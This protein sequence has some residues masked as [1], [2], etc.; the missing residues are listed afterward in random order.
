MERP[1]QGFT[2]RQL[3]WMRRWHSQAHL[4]THLGTRPSTP[5]EW[6]TFLES[7]ETQIARD[8]YEFRGLRWHSVRGK[9]ALSTQ[10]LEDALVI[11]KINDNVRRSYGL[12][13]PNRGSLIRTALQALRENTP[14]TIIRI[15][16]KGCFEGICR[17][18]L[19]RQLRV[20]ARVSYQTIALIDALFAQAA[21]RLGGGLPEGIPRGLTISTSLAELK[22]RELD[23]RLRSQPGTYLLLR[24]VDD[25]LIFSTAPEEQAWLETKTIVSD[26]GLRVNPSKS[27]PFRV[28]CKCDAQCPHGAACPCKQQCK[29]L[30]PTTPLTNLEYLGYKILFYPHNKERRSPNDVY[31]VLSDRKSSR[32]KTRI[33]RSL[34]DCAATGDW[35]LLEDRI[36]YLTA[37]QRVAHAPGRRGLFN[38]LSYT[39]SEYLKP[40]A[41]EGSGTLR[42]LDQFYRAGL[43]RLIFAN[44]MPTN[45]ATLES[46]TFQSGFDHKR[47]TKFPAI[48]VKLIKKCWEA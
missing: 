11:R 27:K 20:D 37:N 40:D 47:R 18:S 14:K 22:L 9:R 28:A 8:S 5:A 35:H 3:G 31:S 12:A 43:R 1:T 6:T 19:L 48:R 29:C 2:R 13:Q 46:L 7:I 16:I 30:T 4:R 21:K 26:C 44:G 15:D 39:H 38:G 33:Y 17:N 10:L 34:M 36:K 42:S 32:I 23:Q 24:Y 25:I 45:K 41:L